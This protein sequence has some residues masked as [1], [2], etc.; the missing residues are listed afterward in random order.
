MFV[1]EVYDARVAGSSEPRMSSA[2]T[3]VDGTVMASNDR[4]VSRT[5]DRWGRRRHGG[6]GG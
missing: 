1:G 3:P 6:D 5:S 2:G 4:Q